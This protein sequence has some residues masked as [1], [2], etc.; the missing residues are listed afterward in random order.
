MK[1]CGVRNFFLLKTDVTSFDIVFPYML[2]LTSFS[3]LTRVFTS[4][5]FK[6]NFNECQILKKQNINWVHARYL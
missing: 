5:W 1:K 2:F 4:S 3:F 6:L